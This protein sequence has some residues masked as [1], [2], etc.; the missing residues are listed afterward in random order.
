[1]F[2]KEEESV[3]S[4]QSP[5]EEHT[6]F[7]INST[8]EQDDGTSPKELVFNSNVPK[9]LNTITQQDF[10]DKE[11]SPLH[12]QV[13]QNRQILAAGGPNQARHSEVPDR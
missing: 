3:E 7:I 10:K 4:A 8:D 12:P 2:F 13:R 6:I 11:G 1:V 9:K 5:V